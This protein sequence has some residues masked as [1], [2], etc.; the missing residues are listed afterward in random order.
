MLSFTKI[1]LKQLGDHNTSASATAL[2]CSLTVIDTV[3]VLSSSIP[4]PSLFC[5]GAF[6]G[7]FTTFAGYSNCSKDADWME[8]HQSRALYSLIVGVLPTPLMRISTMA[9][10]YFPSSLVLG[11]RCGALLPHAYRQV[12]YFY[13][14]ELR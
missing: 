8:S 5:I 7:A 10:S 14:P 9:Y 4:D 1:V 11:F 12:Q 6:A 13:T 2:S 3:Q